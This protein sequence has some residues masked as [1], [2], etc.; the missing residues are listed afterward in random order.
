[1]HPPYRTTSRSRRRRTHPRR[2]EP[3]GPSQ[4]APISPG[5]N[6]RPSGRRRRRSADG[7]ARPR[8]GRDRSLGWGSGRSRTRRVKPSNGSLFSFNARFGCVGPGRFMGLMRL[9]LSLY[10]DLDF[11]VCRVDTPSHFD[12]FPLSFIS[13]LLHTHSH[14]QEFQVLSAQ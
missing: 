10:V 14:V 13:S 8:A 5:R 7:S 9:R 2:S 11:P 4:Q 3:T 6:T 1:M 12:T